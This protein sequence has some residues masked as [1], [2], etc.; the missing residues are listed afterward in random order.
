MDKAYMI[1]TLKTS[2]VKVKNKKNELMLKLN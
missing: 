1:L 2:K